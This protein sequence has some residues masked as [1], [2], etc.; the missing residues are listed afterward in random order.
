MYHV[1]TPQKRRANVLKVF[2]DSPFTQ[3]V[4]YGDEFNDCGCA[5]KWKLEWVSVNGSWSGLV[6]DGKPVNVRLCV[7]FCCFLILL[8]C[9]LKQWHNL[10]YNEGVFMEEE[11][12]LSWK[13][14]Y[15]RMW[16]K[17]ASACS[18]V[19]HSYLYFHG[20]K[21]MIASDCIDSDQN[22]FP[23]YILSF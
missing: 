7:A 1:L 23:D 12:Q 21:L 6:G 5:N 10:Q 22:Q 18:F 4:N 17:D 2:K 8:L 20:K 13:W 9:N 14:I 15:V 11:G 16:R 3:V 19:S